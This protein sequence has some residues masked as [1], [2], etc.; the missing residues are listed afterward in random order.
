MQINQSG[1]LRSS[2]IAVLVAAL[3][4]TLAVVAT[5]SPE[6]TG[7]AMDYA[8]DAAS[9]PSPLTAGLLE[10]GHLLWRPAGVVLR[11]LL[12]RPASGDPAAIRDAQ[13]LLTGISV[14]SAFVATAS[15]GLLVLELVPSLSAALLA[16]A[17]TALGAAIINFGQAGAPY[18]PGVALVSLA[19][20]LGTTGARPT[21]AWRAAPA[22]ALLALGVLVWLPYVL[23]VPAVLAAIC[24]LSPGEPAHRLRAAAIATA[25]CALVG[26]ATYASAA[27]ANGIRSI[28]A[29]AHWIANSSHG[30]SRPGLARVVIGLPRSF[31]HMGTDGR[32]VRRYLVGDPLNPVSTVQI[33]TLPLWPK[34]LLFYLALA[35]VAWFAMRHPRGR[36]LLLL[37]AI[38]ALPVIALGASWS[39]GEEER[40]LA[41]YPLLL[42]LV[43]WAA[44]TGLAERR[45]LVPAAVAAFG[46]LW[47][48]NL[49]AFN[50]LV[51]HARSVA[52]EA[53]IGCVTP[54]LDTQSVIVVPHQADPLVTFSRDRLD[55]PP[56]SVGARVVFLLPPT[57]EKGQSWDAILTSV[58]TTTMGAGGRVWFPAYALDSIPP[59]SVGWVEGGQ[60]VTWSQVRQAFSALRATRRCADTSL[61]EVVGP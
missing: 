23:V 24:L 37:L 16:V 4:G 18:I 61:L 28:P 39:G 55:E 49:W 20:W 14:I 52:Q 2:R 6:N 50:P 41:L 10:P 29:F 48:W 11:N 43:I 30:I 58:V 53:R 40:Y 19:L 26:I 60:V 33:A 36:T 42:L 54:M 27:W 9:A 51:T 22:G 34:L 57:F 56:R 59:R 12:G 1:G 44:F 45:R 7:D 32:E 13:R 46:L 47:L 15:I 25:T 38:A 21:R 8:R 17:M 35:V 31:V 5:T 3:L